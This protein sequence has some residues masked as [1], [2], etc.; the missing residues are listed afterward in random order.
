[1]PRKKLEERL[2]YTRDGATVTGLEGVFFIVKCACG[3]EFKCNKEKLRNS[4]SSM[5]HCNQCRHK[6]MVEV[7]TRGRLIQ[8]GQT[9]PPLSDK[10]GYDPYSRSSSLHP[11]AK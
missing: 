7:G 8:T 5:L 3:T 1:M 6:R 11:G 2:G 4:C 10:P 9:F